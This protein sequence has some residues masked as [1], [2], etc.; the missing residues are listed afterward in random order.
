MRTPRLIAFALFVGCVLLLPLAAHAIQR[1]DGARLRYVVPRG[2]VQAPLNDR[3][4]ARERA[5]KIA[6]ALDVL[7]VGEQDA[8][9]YARLDAKNK[10][11]AS[12]TIC[13]WEL[14]DTRGDDVIRSQP[15]R[16]VL[17]RIESSLHDLPSLALHRCTRRQI[18][19]D[20]VGLVSDMSYQNVKAGDPSRHLRLAITAKDRTF[21]LMTLD[22]PQSELDDYESLWS[23]VTGTMRVVSNT[24]N[25]PFLEQHLFHLLFGALG[26][27]LLV[28]LSLIWKTRARNPVK[29]L[30]GHEELSRAADQLPPLDAMDMPA[31]PDVREPKEAVA[32]SG[33]V[34]ATAPTRSDGALTTGAALADRIRRNSDRGSGS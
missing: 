26:L 13:T 18:N 8:Q 29:R 27:V 31:Q 17:R 30:S 3:A 4:E 7:L 16:D 11:S 15:N 22:V 10:P 23:G 19:S 25:I 12:I 21:I 24:G 6:A 5:A 20:M 2:Y 14:A 34:I 32:S 1:V 33:R 9:M 28:F